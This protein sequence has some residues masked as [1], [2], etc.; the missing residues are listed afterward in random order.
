[1][2][3]ARSA[4]WYR[5]PVIWIGFLI[6]VVSVIM[7]LALIN[8]PDLLAKLG[9]ANLNLVVAG[10]CI[11][12]ASAFIRAARWQAILGSRVNYWKIF[13]AENIGYLINIVLPLRAGEPARAYVLNRQQPDVS[14]FEALSTVLVAR[15]VDMI[16]VILLLG[17]VLPALD[18]PGPIKVAGYSMLV[19]VIIA[20]FVLIVG[21]YA[22]A[23]L[24]AVL[25]AILTRLLPAHLAQRLLQWAD[26]FLTGLAVLRS[27]RRL[28]WLGAT[29]VALWLSYIVFYDFILM[30]FWPAPPFSWGILAIC[31]ASLSL[32]I[33]SSPSSVGVFH[34]AVAFV[35]APYLSTDRAVAYAI[36]LHATETIG[37]AGFGL[38]SLAATG[39]SLARLNIEL[40]NPGQTK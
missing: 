17:L 3:T 5:R 34:A 15:V 35:M 32:T 39:T 13:H 37:N 23:W 18:V 21:A 14:P 38:I 29:M 31:A 6:S 22:R 30:A 24:V 19:L 27:A 4:A 8:I 40:A 33:P 12:I 9:D 11:V 7:L 1:M 26:E 28:A 16:A 2:T 25:R 36:V 10:F 20:V